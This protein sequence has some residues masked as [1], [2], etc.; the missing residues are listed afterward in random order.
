ML[1]YEWLIKE[2][3]YQLNHPDFE[4]CRRWP[5]ATS[6]GRGRIWHPE[7][8]KTV[9]VHRAAFTIAKGKPPKYFVCHKCGVG[10]CINIFH[11]YDGTQ[12]DN[13]A[14]TIAMGR[15]RNGCSYRLSDS[16]ILGIAQLITNGATNRQI[17]RQFDISE[18]YASAIR[19]GQRR[20]KLTGFKPG[21]H[22][23]QYGVFPKG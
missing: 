4:N 16:Q 22:G 23:K 21:Q 5:F 20:A 17:A 7:L 13:V 2:V 3:E 8:K 9:L 6:Q 14:D 12:A 1:Q 11:L 10:D 18:G 15:F 19:H